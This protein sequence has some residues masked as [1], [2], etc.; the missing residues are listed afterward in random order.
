MTKVLYFYDFTTY[1]CIPVGLL[2]I[3]RKVHMIKVESMNLIRLDMPMRAG[4]L[5]Q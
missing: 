2:C 4:M 3:S 1:N 5:S